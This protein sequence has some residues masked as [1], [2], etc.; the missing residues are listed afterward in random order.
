[1]IENVR[2]HGDIKLITSKRRRNYLMLEPNYY[3]ANLFLE[4]GGKIKK[5]KAQRSV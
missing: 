5:Q 3:T 1:M 4:L 2:K